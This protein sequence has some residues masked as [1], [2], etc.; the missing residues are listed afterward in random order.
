MSKSVRFVCS[1][2]SVLSKANTHTVAVMLMLT[3]CISVVL[4]TWKHPI[5]A[6]G[7]FYWM[8]FFCVFGFVLRNNC[9]GDVICSHRPIRTGQISPHVITVSGLFAS[10]S[11]CWQ[12]HIHTVCF[13]C[14]LPFPPPF[15]HPPFTQTVYHHYFACTAILS[16]IYLPQWCP[17]HLLLIFCLFV[18]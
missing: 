7:W 17:G 3:E 15:T 9:D 16:L 11:Q 5:Q 12:N 18:N 1:L 6:A 14:S 13:L 10:V 4:S 8:T 2:L